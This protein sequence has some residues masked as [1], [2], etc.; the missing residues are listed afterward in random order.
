[1][2]ETTVEIPVVFVVFGG[3]VLA[4]VLIARLPVSNYTG[5]SVP[6]VV[7]R[8]KLGLQ[9]INSGLFF[10]G[11]ML[12]LVLFLLLFAGLVW[13]IADIIVAAI[14]KP[15]EQEAV[16]AWRFSILKLASLTAVLGAVVALPFTLIKLSLTQQQN[17]IS[18]EG[19]ITDRINRAVEQLGHA[20]PSVRMGAILQL[21]RILRDS[22]VDRVMVLETLN[23]YIKER[24][25]IEAR[26]NEDIDRSDLGVSIDVQAALNV[27]LRTGKTK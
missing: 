7:L 23:A 8:D 14:P 24:S 21:E 15:A 13:A 16:W 26:E 12:W 2:Y 27:L 3:A 18:Q 4:S 25:A 11:F 19:L 9:G 22:E 17:R 1:M 20:E 5:Q 6:L 10:I